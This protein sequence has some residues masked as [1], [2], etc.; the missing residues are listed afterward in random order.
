MG[1]MKGMIWE[2]FGRDK[3]HLSHSLSLLY[4][5]VSKDYG[6]DEAKTLHTISTSEVFHKTY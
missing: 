3:K 5:G 4:K 6:R 1:E 2:R